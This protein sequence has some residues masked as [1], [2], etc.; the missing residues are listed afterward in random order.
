MQVMREG[1]LESHAK[2]VERAASCEHSAWLGSSRL[3]S[4]PA[5]PQRWLTARE[6]ERAGPASVRAKCW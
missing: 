4:E 6:F 5:S 1:Y 2:A 3:A